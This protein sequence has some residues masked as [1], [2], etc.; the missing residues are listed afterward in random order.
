MKVNRKADGHEDT[1]LTEQSKIGDP[2]SP[3]T[4]RS[5][6]L[7]SSYHEISGAKKSQL[8]G[9]TKHQTRPQ[10]KKGKTSVS[11]NNKSNEHKRKM[12]ANA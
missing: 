4:V 1:T 11:N 9:A 2:T 6:Y 10:V 7:K 3:N 12:S 8:D 5:P